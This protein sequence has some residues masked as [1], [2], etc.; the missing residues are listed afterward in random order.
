MK[1]TKAI[2]LIVLGS[3]MIATGFAF[4]ETDRPALDQL[5]GWT[6]DMPVVSAPSKN[7]AK[8]TV[9]T[10]KAATTGVIAPA[11]PAP[12]KVEAAKPAPT[13]M[14][15]A[16]KYFGDNQSQIVSAVAIGLLA[17]LIIGTGGAGLAIGILAFALFKFMK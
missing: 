15:S 8:E 6:I 16:K 11:V 13:F 7:I 10:T 12:V 9:T 1:N 4:A 5:K 17:F 3:F 14:E 2:L